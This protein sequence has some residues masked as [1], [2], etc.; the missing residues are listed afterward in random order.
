MAMANHLLPAVRLLPA[1]L[2]LLF[3]RGAVA[4]HAPVQLRL[5]TWNMEWL[6]DPRTAL[7][8]RIAC[9]DGGESALPCDVARGLARDSADLA[10]MARHARRLG[11]DVI[12][13]QEVQD[14]A[15]ARRVFRGYRICMNG[16]AGVQHV[17]FA[18]R[19]GLAR[20]CGRPFDA[21]AVDG[22]GRPG[23]QLDI[24]VPGLGTIALLVVHLKSGCAHDP[25]QSAS[26]ACRLLAA[27]ARVLG[28]WIRERSHAGTR[29]VVLGDFNRGGLPD[30]GDAFWSLLGPAAFHASAQALPFAN[31]SWGAPY[32]DF[33]DHI[34][35]AIPLDTALQPH[36]FNQLRFRQA[37]AVRYIL[38][39]HCPLGVSLNARRDL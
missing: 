27:Q 20:D 14:E 12:A 26:E 13:F 18:V 7:A 38:S 25:L 31:C 28:E 22:Q 5:A 19:P 2:A 10:V 30:A 16:G 36:A 3:A 37:D 17:G 32:R 24:S 6:V 23:L 9:R 1:A 11:A 21:L 29:F 35:V 39:D 15:I 33:I 8:A 34:L 4:T